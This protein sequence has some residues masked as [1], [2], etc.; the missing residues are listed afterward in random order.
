MLSAAC[1]IHRDID[2]FFGSCR[3]FVQLSSIEHM[4]TYTNLPRQMEDERNLFVEHDEVLEYLV[5]TVVSGQLLIII[6]KAEDITEVISHVPVVRS[7]F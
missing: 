7:I 1:Q 5:L 2:I 4:R 3:I 6:T